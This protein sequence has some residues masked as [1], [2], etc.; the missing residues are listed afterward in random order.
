MV[1]ALGGLARKSVEQA[2]RLFLVQGLAQFAAP[3]APNIAL[4][5][6]MKD[7]RL[8]NLYAAVTEYQKLRDKWKGDTQAATT[9]FTNKYG[10]DA[11]Y[12]LEPKNLR[13][14][15]G[16]PTSSEGVLWR[17]TNQKF[18]DAH[19][20]T[21]GYFVPQPKKQGPY[22][23]YLDA[24]ARGDIKALSVAQWYA[25]ADQRMGQLWYSQSRSQFPASLD[26]GERTQLDKIKN[27]IRARWPGW[28]QTIVGVPGKATTDEKIRDFVGIPGKPGALDDPAVKGSVLAETI[29]F[30]LKGRQSVLDQ[31][32]LK[33]LNGSSDTTNAAKDALFRYGDQ[34]ARKNPEFV[35]VWNDLFQYEVQP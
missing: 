4:D 33:S 35:Q 30:Y 14:A 25:L 8:L 10:P 13:T 6:P 24:I 22:Q 20:Q 28:D 11:I 26:D 12:A 27:Q 23:D 34:I 15:Y 17:K 16:V 9:E 31:T 18:A 21:Y 3:T 29:R 32:G 2:K 5:A 1:D 19:G 7:G